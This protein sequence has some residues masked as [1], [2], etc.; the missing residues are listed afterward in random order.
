MM[1]RMRIRDDGRTVVQEIQ[2]SL[3]VSAKTTVAVSATAKDATA[4]QLHHSAL[5]P[6]LTCFTSL[7]SPR[8][9]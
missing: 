2:W 6:A 1:T 8:R 9:A 5:L 7:F 4:I 3:V